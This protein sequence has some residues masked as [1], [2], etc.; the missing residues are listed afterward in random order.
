MIKNL[1]LVSALIWSAGIIKPTALCM[2]LHWKILN[3][4]KAAFYKHI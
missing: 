3:N 1:D 2:L 4:I